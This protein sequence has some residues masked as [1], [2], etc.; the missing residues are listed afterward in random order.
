MYI[1]ATGRDDGY[2]RISFFELADDI[3]RVRCD[4]TEPKDEE[5]AR[6]QPYGG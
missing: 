6:N 5:E 4:Y 3:S 2:P 1:G